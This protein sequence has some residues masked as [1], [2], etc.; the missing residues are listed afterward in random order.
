MNLGH[1]NEIG[2][3]HRLPPDYPKELAEDHGEYWYLPEPTPIAGCRGMIV[4]KQ[5]GVGFPVGSGLSASAAC[6]AY[7]RGILEGR[8]D[9]IINEC[10]SDL[11]LVIDI[12][13]KCP[14]TQRGM[15]IPNRQ[16]ERWYNLLATLPAVVF[17][18]TP[19]WDYIHELMEAEENGI[20]RFTVK[21][22]SERIEQVV[23][24]NGP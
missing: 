19:L 16:R 20:F 13:T 5:D 11:D 17:S 12:L 22:R 24:P 10:T 18:D 7:E 15:K 6:W 2:N 8:H 3:G 1:T 14:P 23:P 4:R 9:L 21:T